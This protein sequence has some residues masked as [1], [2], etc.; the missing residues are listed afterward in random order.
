MARKNLLNGF[1]FF[2]AIILLVSM[3]S[4]RKRIVPDTSELESSS[5]QSDIKEA[6]SQTDTSEETSTESEQENNDESE[7]SN[8]SPASSNEKQQ[9]NTNTSAPASSIEVPDAN[10]GQ[11]KP[12]EEGNTIGAVVDQYT[13]LLNEGL[14][15]LYECQI[16]FVYLELV[17]EYQTINRNSSLHQFILEAGGYNVA[18]KLMD[19]SLVVNTEW[20]KRKNPGLIVKFVSPSV[21]GSNVTS[22][23]AASSFY[24][25]YVSQNGW[26]GISAVI[27]RKVILLSSEL[28]NSE[29]GKFIGKLY[30]ARAMHPEL[31]SD[32]DVD[33]ICSQVLGEKGC[34]YYGLT[35]GEQYVD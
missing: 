1:V 27:N 7:S 2:M 23:Q 16:P 34:Y 28:L 24:S 5:V 32:F 20:L 15:T 26:N 12:S 9:V 13:N 18:E 22:T 6:E 11:A 29:N 25:Q 3:S 21:L 17:P 4:C 14:G 31:F 10:D 19:D 33:S 30:L 35:M 8:S